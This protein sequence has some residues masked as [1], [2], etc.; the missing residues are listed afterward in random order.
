MLPIYYLK[1]TDE[2]FYPDE[3]NI[4]EEDICHCFPRG[5]LWEQWMH[6]SSARGILGVTLVLFLFAVLSGQ[7]GPT[8][9]NWMKV[10]LV[11][12]SSVALFIVATVPDHFLE[13]HL[14][15]HVARKHI[16]KIF[17]WTFGALLLMHIL[18]DHLHLEGWMQESQLLILVIACL[19]GLIPESGPH[20]LFL[21]LFAENTIPFSIF[22]A[23]SIVQ[24]GHGMLPLLAKSRRDFLKVKGINFVVGLLAG[25]I[26]YVSGW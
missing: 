1:K 10:T 12:L 26:G 19:V 23:S 25:M 6:C 24:D 4:H 13:E 22:L 14:W 18:L 16:P 3:F 8:S 21:T 11:I 7:L 20:L 5:K 15:N 17:I 2:P 9:W